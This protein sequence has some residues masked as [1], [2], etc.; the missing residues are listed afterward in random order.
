MKFNDLREAV[1]SQGFTFGFELECI[2]PEGFY[3]EDLHLPIE[4]KA[5]SDSSIKIDDEYADKNYVGEEYVSEPLTLNPKTIVNVKKSIIELS[6]H[7]VR[8]NSSCGFH[9]HYSYSNMTFADIC[10]LLTNLSIDPDSAKLFSEFEGIDFFSSEYADV[11]F[12]EDIRDHLEMGMS[13]NIVFSTEKYRVIRIHPQGTLEW[14]GPR[15]FMN[16]AD[17]SLIDNFFIR[18]YKNADIINK[19]VSKKE[20][21]IGDKVFNKNEFYKDLNSNTS[22]IKTSIKANNPN[23]KDTRFS[24]LQDPSTLNDIFKFKPELGKCRMSNISAKIEN[25]RLLIT[26]G[27]FSGV[28]SGVNFSQTVIESSNL[29]DCEA[30]GRSITKSKLDGCKLISINTLMCEFEKCKMN[31]VSSSRS[32]IDQCNIYKGSYLGCTIKNTKL[33]DDVFVD[34]ESTTENCQTV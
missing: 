2:H 3:I 25:N 27:K 31:N 21:K 30:T 23:R 26:G 4:F 16:N 12:L 29:K 1:T 9:V 22:S 7:G 32:E 17:L 11:S 10:W 19:L 24:P 20:V 13:P 6:K 15:D 14:R 34:S 8:T 18:L 33:M 28:I 5:T